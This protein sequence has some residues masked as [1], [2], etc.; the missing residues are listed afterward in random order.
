MSY[1]YVIF[2]FDGTLA[3][4]LPF[5][6]SC[7]GELARTH[8]FR[9]PA[10]EEWPQLRAASL[11]GLLDS[12]GIPLWRVPRIARHYRRLL[13]QRGDQVAPFAEI[14]Q[15]LDRLQTSGLQLGLA[16]SNS[17]AAVHQVL[18][19]AGHL[20]PDGEFDI[21]LLGKA[22]R[23]ARLIRRQGVAPADA[24]YVGDELRDL[25]AARR[26]GL[27]CAAVAWGYGCP[28]TLRAQ[29]PDLFFEQPAEL[30]RLTSSPC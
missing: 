10:P 6:L 15:A 12:L 16:T 29:R 21:P 22:R 23:L 8:G 30:L 4:S 18:P 5:L 26:A 17:A 19:Q 2:D 24:L 3:D 20:F 13:A 25:Q 11:T 27:G 28:T 9:Q 1:R 14:P 7:L